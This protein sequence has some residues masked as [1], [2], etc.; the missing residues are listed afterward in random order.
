MYL[1]FLYNMPIRIDIK[2]WISCYPPGIININKM[3]SI[4][5]MGW[6]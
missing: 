2:Y 5:S 6:S 3:S 4:V 1:Y